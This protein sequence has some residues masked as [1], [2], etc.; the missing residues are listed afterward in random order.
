MKNYLKYIIIAII[1]LSGYSGF[2]QQDPQFTQYMYNTM[3]VNPAYTGSRGHLSILGMYRSQWVGVNGSPETQVLAIDTPVGNNV[4]LGLVIVNDKLGPANETFLD[5]NFSYTLR[6]NREN[7]KL[8][9]GLKAGGRLFNVDF[10]KGSYE[11][12]DTAFQ[13]NI[14]NKFLPTIGAGVYYH[15]GKSYLGLAVPNFF[16]EE[17]YD[18]EELQIATERLHYFIIGGTVFDITPDVK[19]KPAF[20]FKWVPGAPVIAD[21]SAN[22]MIKEKFTLGLAYRWDDSF[23][24]LLGLQISPNL[25]LGYAY[26]FTTTDLKNYNYGTHEV[27]LRYEFKSL[28]RKLKSPRFY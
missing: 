8:S 6:L 26:D 1:I 14:N 2:S 17:H 20:F 3:G 23:S 16:A 10:T 5:G 22:A 21:V 18:S 7:R 25:S 24:A 9:F 12:P 4:G 27:F 28:Q 15:T 13:T 19:L 11:N